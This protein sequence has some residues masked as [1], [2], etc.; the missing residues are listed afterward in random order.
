M[1]LLH[2]LGV[3][4]NSWSYQLSA[5][6]Q[7][8]MHPLAVDV[9]GFGKSVYHQP[10]W[11]FRG[12]AGELAQFAQAVIDS[13]LV[14]VGLSMGGALALQLTLGRPQWVSRLMLINGF[15]C[16]RPTRFS[17]IVYLVGRGIAAYLLGVVWQAQMV[18]GRIFPGNDQ[19][20]MRKALIESI[21]RTEADI[22]RAAM[23]SLA[24]FD[25]R[26]RLG[27]I[28][29][30][31]LVLTGE[32]DNTVA[33]GLQSELAAGIPYARQTIIE[34]GGHALSVDQP[35]AINRVLIDFIKGT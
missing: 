32:L 25:V 26:K 15:A 7:A 23:R 21:S 5:L 12:V 30:P 11:T 8:G 33:A 17:D 24:L 13:N 6:A 35:D 34:G 16:L 31:T 2:G 3:D 18:A 14:V 4:P 20:Q 29:V 19:Q 9:P 27:E 1:L 10:R 28:G 22:H